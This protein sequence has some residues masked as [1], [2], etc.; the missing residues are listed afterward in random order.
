M[1]VADELLGKGMRIVSV[2]SEGAEDEEVYEAKGQAIDVP[3]AVLV[4]QN[5]ASASEI[6]AAAIQENGIGKGYWGCGHEAC[7]RDFYES[8]DSGGEFKVNL[9]SV[10]NTFETVMNIYQVA[11][12]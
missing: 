9:Q 8:Q 10:K 5:S 3:V 2:G 1:G 4:N 12:K 11:R 7:I 6:L